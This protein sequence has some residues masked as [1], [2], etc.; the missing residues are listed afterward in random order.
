MVCD[1]GVRSPCM[2][3]LD[4]QLA[5]RPLQAFPPMPG[6]TL[7]SGCEERQRIPMMQRTV[8]RLAPC[9]LRCGVYCNAAYPWLA[10]LK[11][12]MIARSLRI[13]GC[14]AP[15]QIGLRD[16]ASRWRV[17]CAS[18]PCGGDVCAELRK[19][20]ARVRSSSALEESCTIAR[21]PEAVSFGQPP[22]FCAGRLCSALAK[23]T[24]IPRRGLRLACRRWGRSAGA[25]PCFQLGCAPSAT[26]SSR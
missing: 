23:R 26:A 18:A 1:A 6:R 7:A 5:W 2:C 21:S 9:V 20:L 4:Q 24:G 17:Q 12:P 11:Q 10:P 3:S 15:Q 19:M 8:F 14:F 25:I 16:A 22:L 13:R